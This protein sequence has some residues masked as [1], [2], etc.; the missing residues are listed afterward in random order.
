[1]KYESPISY[2]AKIIGKVKVFVI[3]R[4]TDG[5]TDRKTDE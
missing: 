4:G 1:M 2:G 3:D 5:Q